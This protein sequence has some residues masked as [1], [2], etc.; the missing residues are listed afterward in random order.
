MMTLFKALFSCHELYHF[1]RTF[2]KFLISSLI[3]ECLM[4]VETSTSRFKDIVTYLTPWTFSSVR[5]LVTTSANELALQSTCFIGG[6]RVWCVW[7]DSP[8]IFCISS[9]QTF[10]ATTRGYISS[11]ES[12]RDPRTGSMEIVFISKSRLRCLR[13]VFG[14]SPVVFTSSPNG[15]LGSSTRASIIERSMVES[16]VRL[17]FCGVNA[18]IEGLTPNILERLFMTSRSFL[19][20][21]RKVIRPSIFQD[22][23]DMS[24]AVHA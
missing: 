4:S 22:T 7:A 15:I 5:V 17:F 14:L 23:Q 1:S 18:C 9:I 2:S 24:G 11:P 13:T 19:V 20:H 21:R 3:K 10:P 16:G 8:I 6:S 12:V